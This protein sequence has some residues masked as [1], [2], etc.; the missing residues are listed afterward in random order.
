MWHHTQL[1]G[2]HE[3]SLTFCPDPPDQLTTVVLTCISLMTRDAEYSL[4]AYGL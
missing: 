2:W 3:V 1:T 4:C